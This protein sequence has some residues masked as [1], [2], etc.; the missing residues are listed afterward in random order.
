MGAVFIDIA[1]AIDTVWYD[2]LLY[3]MATQGINPRLVKIV[4]LYL[5]GRTFAT[6]HGDE[7]TSRCPIVAGVPQ[8]SLLVPTLFN[9]FIADLPKFPAVEQAIYADNTAL[10]TTSRD[11]NKVLR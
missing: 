1:R 8:R 7:L 10:Y 11:E 2:G 4:Q 6:R 9:I 5:R 3:K